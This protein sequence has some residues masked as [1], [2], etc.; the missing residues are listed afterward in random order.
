[1]SFYINKASPLELFSVIIIL[2]I[3][4]VLMIKAFFCWGAGQTSQ[5]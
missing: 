1:M 3:I 5:V 2:A 4:L